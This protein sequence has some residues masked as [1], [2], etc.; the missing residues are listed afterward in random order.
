MKGIERD[1]VI[2]WEVREKRKKKKKNFTRRGS[3]RSES[4][5]NSLRGL[6][7]GGARDLL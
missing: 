4:S 3:S 7:L 6:R 2:K 5:S 1:I